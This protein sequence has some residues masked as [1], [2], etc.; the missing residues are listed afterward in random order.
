METCMKQNSLA[1]L[2]GSRKSMIQQY[3][4][5]ARSITG[6]NVW[7]ETFYCLIAGFKTPARIRRER[8]DKFYEKLVAVMTKSC[9]GQVSY[10]VPD[11][12]NRVQYWDKVHIHY[13]QPQKNSFDKDVLKALKTR[14]YA[15]I[16]NYKQLY[17]NGGL[18]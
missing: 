17:K 12:R 14:H 3:R 16:Q 8:D 9:V 11:H 6:R 13:V 5:H 10:R 7:L 18:V 15:Q 1:S 4:R 2:L